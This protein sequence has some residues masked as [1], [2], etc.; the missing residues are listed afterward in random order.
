MW[1]QQQNKSLFEAFPSP[2]LCIEQPTTDLFLSLIKFVL[3][4]F[5]I[6]E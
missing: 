3:S 2:R 5:N 4:Q 6:H 1:K